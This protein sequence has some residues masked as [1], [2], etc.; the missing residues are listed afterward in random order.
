MIIRP[1]TIPRL[2][3][4]PDTTI[5]LCMIFCAALPCP[6]ELRKAPT[7]VCAKQR[8]HFVSNK[9]I[10]IPSNENHFGHLSQKSYQ[11]NCKLANVLPT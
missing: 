2:S 5:Q 7:G 3:A 10:H 9:F 4:V 1:V 11:F 6:L 8:N